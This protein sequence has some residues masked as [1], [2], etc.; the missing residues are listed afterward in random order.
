MVSILD[1]NERK[2]GAVGGVMEDQEGRRKIL[3]LTFQPNCTF[4]YREFKAGNRIGGSLVDGLSSANLFLPRK[5]FDRAG[6]FFQGLPRDEDTD[7]CM[8]LAEMGYT[9]CQG[10]DTV[11]LNKMTDSGRDSGAFAHF[12]DPHKYVSDL[13]DARIALL[14]RHFPWRLPVLW[15]LDLIV[16]PLL[17]VQ[18]KTGKIVTNRFNKAI[19]RVTLT[20]LLYCAA[21]QISSY[22]KGLHSFLG[23]AGPL[24]KKWMVVVAPANS[25]VSGINLN[26]GIHQLTG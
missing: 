5:I 18:K 17:F 9:F 26:K 11:V 8:T 4:L 12:A 3:Q 23:Q 13:L 7:L 16:I 22:F 19:P 14:A 21:K 25:S 10:L 2:I 1:A 6:G 15:L 20:L 24:L